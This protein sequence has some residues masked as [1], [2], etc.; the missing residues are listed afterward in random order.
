[1]SSVDLSTI[2]SIASSITYRL[3]LTLGRCTCLQ[4]L[5]VVEKSAIELYDIY[6]VPPNQDAETCQVREWSGR[7]LSLLTEQASQSKE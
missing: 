2:L 6:L 3:S 7:S 4:G 5:R 1:M